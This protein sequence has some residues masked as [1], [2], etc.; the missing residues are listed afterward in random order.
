MTGLF[1]SHIAIHSAS[2][3]MLTVD[4]RIVR[5]RHKE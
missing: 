5:H 2:A 4:V 3:M 1:H